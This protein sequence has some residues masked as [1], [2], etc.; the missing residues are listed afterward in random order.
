MIEIKTNEKQECNDVFVWVDF[1]TQEPSDK[2]LFP[3]KYTCNDPHFAYLLAAHFQKRLEEAIKQAHRD[4]YDQG[5][6]DGRGH[7]KRK[8][9]F[10]SCF[11]NDEHEPAW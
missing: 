4:A 1:G 5:Y 3:F 10:L 7:K 8:K 2:S 9:N 11:G 6:N